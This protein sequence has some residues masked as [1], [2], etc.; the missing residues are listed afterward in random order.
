VIHC[1]R[2]EGGATAAATSTI[3][4]R[5]RERER[6]TRK[7]EGEGTIGGY[8]QKKSTHLALM[9]ST[10]DPCATL[11][12]DN[13]GFISQMKDYILAMDSLKSLWIQ[14]AFLELKDLNDTTQKS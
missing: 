11:A 7:V 10:C 1:H 2:F 8:R 12:D 5:E 4:E 6:G 13:F 3:R 14:T 9:C